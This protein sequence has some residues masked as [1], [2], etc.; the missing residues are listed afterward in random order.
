MYINA[1][2][3]QN[4]EKEIY[5]GV[6][7]LELLNDG[8]THKKNDLAETVG[9]DSRSVQRL[10]EELSKNYRRF[11]E[12]ELPLFERTGNQYRLLI[13]DQTMEQNQFLV[14][15]IRHSLSYRILHL[16]IAGKARTI[17]ELSEKLY[18]SE[19]TIRRKVKNLRKELTPLDIAIDRGEVLFAHQNRSCEC[20]YPF[21]IG[22][23]SA[24]RTGHLHHCSM[25]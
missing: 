1:L 10:L 14:D 13:A 11:T 2:D 17:K 12:T 7:L 23:C 16:L 15:L 24:E 18:R 4:Y 6:R 21:I 9:L 3:L 8:K 22:V 20:I 19:S 5:F 25:N